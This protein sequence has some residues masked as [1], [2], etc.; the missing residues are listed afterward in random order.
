MDKYGFL[1]RVSRAA[2]PTVL[3]TVLPIVLPVLRAISIIV[4]CGDEDADC[5][6]DET[7]EN[8]LDL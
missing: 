4:D 1:S 6:D 7:H 8:D 5:D 3:P 2:L